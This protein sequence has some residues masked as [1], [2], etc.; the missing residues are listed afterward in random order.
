MNG[1]SSEDIMKAIDI[2]LQVPLSQRK[3]EEQRADF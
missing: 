2:V 1:A 3:L